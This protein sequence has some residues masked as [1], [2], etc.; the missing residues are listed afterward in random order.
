MVYGL[1]LGES[2]C[3]LGSFIQDYRGLIGFVSVFQK[4]S[5]FI[6]FSLMKELLYSLD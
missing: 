3:G 1:V 2:A 6:N 4:K 5:L